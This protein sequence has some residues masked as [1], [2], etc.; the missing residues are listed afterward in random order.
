MRQALAD[1]GPP[2]PQRPDPPRGGK[3]RR[4]A[5][6]LAAG[7]VGFAAFVFSQ[8]AHFGIPAG[9]TALPTPAPAPTSP[10]RWWVGVW[11]TEGANDAPRLEL[12]P[13]GWAVTGRLILNHTHTYLIA[14]PVLDSQTTEAVILFAV[15]EPDSYLPAVRYYLL[16]RDGPNAA[17]LYRLRQPPANQPWGATLIPTA[18]DRHTRVA[19]L[20]RSGTNA[21]PEQAPGQELDH[22]DR[23]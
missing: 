22:R 3:A 5:W 15:P 12:A 1:L 14:L 8:R 6:A 4:I 11:V 13:R 16:R 19:R 18:L 23:P 9:P 17:E 2:F 21:A 10:T 20:L 7:A